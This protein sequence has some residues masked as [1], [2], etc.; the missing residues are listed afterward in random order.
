MNKHKEVILRALNNY[1]GDNYERAAAAFR[2]FTPTEMGAQ[3]RVSGQTRQEIIDGYRKHTL[4]V[5]N[6]IHFVEQD[7]W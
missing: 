1:R 3:H 7:I 4:E 2:N 6:A 5:E